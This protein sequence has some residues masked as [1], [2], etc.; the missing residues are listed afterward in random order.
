MDVAKLRLLRLRLM[1]DLM[2]LVIEYAKLTCIMLMLFRTSASSL[3]IPY[4][5][6]IFFENPAWV[7]KSDLCAAMIHIASFSKT[8]KLIS[9]QFSLMFFKPVT[10]SLRSQAS[11]PKP[12]GFPFA[13]YFKECYCRYLKTSH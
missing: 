12:Y 9:R 1:P 6:P 7:F 2:K 5:H 4:T 11:T 3:S 13:L 10:C 8:L